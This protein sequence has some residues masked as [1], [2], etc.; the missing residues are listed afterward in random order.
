M[1]FFTMSKYSFCSGRKGKEGKGR[2]RG[3]EGRNEGREGREREREGEK[4]GGRQPL[5]VVSLSM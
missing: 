1:L 4:E 5:E 2:K 3:R